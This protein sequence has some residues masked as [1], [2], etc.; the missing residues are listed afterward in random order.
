MRTYG[1]EDFKSIL[2]STEILTVK[3][4]KG[5][6]G[7]EAEYKDIR[8]IKKRIDRAMEDVEVLETGIDVDC[9]VDENIRLKDMEEI[10]NLKMIW[11]SYCPKPLFLI[12]D[13]EID[14]A[15]VRMPYATLMVFKVGDIECKKEFC[16]KYLE[17]F[18]A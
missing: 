16:S 12:K 7:I 10:Y 18:L 14:T 1:I 3:G 2:E 9:E 6:A 13:V 15:K 5:S 11:N 4:H 17:K 8:R